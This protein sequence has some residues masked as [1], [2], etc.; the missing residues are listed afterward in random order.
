MS[1]HSISDHSR[2][3]ELDLESLV[4]LPV[5]EARA[6]VEGAGGVLRAAAPN[7]A[8]TMDYRPDRVTLIVEDENVISVYGRG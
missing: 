8:L 7:S 4:G 3:A 6:R 1:D 2:L 5:T